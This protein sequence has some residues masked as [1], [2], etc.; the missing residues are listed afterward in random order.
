MLYAGVDYHKRYSQVH[1]VDEQGRTRASARLA[2]DFATLRGFFAALAQPCRAVVEAGWN[3]GVMYDWLDTIENV[4]AV[5]L[6]HPYRVRAIAAAQVKT[7]AIDAHTLAQLLRVNLIP[8]AYVPGSATRRL[9]EVVRQ[10]V[11]LVRMRTMV[12]NPYGQNIRHISSLCFKN[13]DEPEKNRFPDFQP[14]HAGSES[15]SPRC[16]LVL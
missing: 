2:N 5:E 8:R 13:S 14:S 12:K 1:V 11:F 16:P 9:R 4:S 7:D 6:A 3:W 15:I 10:R